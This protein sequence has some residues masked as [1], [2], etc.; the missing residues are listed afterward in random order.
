MLPRLRLVKMSCCLLIGHLSTSPVFAQPDLQT[1]ILAEKAVQELPPG[2]LFWRVE[3]IGPENKDSA[4]PM[5][6]V[7]VVSG[8]VWLVTLGPMGS[9]TVGATKLIEIGPVQAAQAA[10]YV[11]S[12][13]RV[14]GANTANVAKPISS[15]SSAFFVLKGRLGF[16]TPRR[17]THRGAGQGVALAGDGPTRIF[18]AGPGDLAAFVMSIDTADDASARKQPAL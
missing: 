9:A 7:G 2:P 15:E 8:E 13:G 5:S 4:A 18:N 11:L 3:T 12:L 16:A 14:R 1:T 10:R 17:T 6:L